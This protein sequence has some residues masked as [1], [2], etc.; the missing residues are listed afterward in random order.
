MEEFSIG[1]YSGRLSN[2]R[3]AWCLASCDDRAGN[4]RFHRSCD[5]A[6]ALASMSAS[7]DRFCLAAELETLSEMLE[8]DATAACGERDE[9]VS[10]P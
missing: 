7:F 4:V 3:K 10:D 6:E 1:R 9:R 2:R 8:Q 5:H